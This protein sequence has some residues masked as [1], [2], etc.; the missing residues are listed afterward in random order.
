[1]EAG[2]Q[3]EGVVDAGGCD[4]E[5]RREKEDTFPVT[6]NSTSQGLPGL[7]GSTLGRQN[8]WNTSSGKEE[9]SLSGKLRLG[10]S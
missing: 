1:M 7:T 4:G 8:T 5:G 9:S 3:D 2:F 6:R 10:L